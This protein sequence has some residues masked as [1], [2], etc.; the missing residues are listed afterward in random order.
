MQNELDEHINDVKKLSGKD[1]M[2]E[3]TLALLT[4]I[5]ELANEW[6]GFKF[7]KDNP[8]PRTRLF[9]IKDDFGHEFELDFD[10]RLVQE[11]F[12]PEVREVNP[13]LEEFVDCVH[14]LL[15][16]G[17][18]SGFTYSQGEPMDIQVYEMI[19]I[20]PLF[21]NFYHSVNRFRSEPLPNSYVDM[22]SYLFS[23]GN[24]LGITENDIYNAYL[25]KNKINFERQESGY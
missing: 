11:N 10:P 7:W 15:S 21:I 6:R 2:E 20:T 24:K 16:I 1:V 23:I 4:E 22:W 17:N 18:Y 8:Q 9:K 13:I 25:E 3:R 5:G 12:Y 19:D 14:F